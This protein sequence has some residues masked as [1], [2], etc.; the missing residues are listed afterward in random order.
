MSGGEKQRLAILRA[1]VTDPKVIIADEPASNLDEENAIILKEFFEEER[2]RDK[3]VLVVSHNDIFFDTQGG[4]SHPRYRLNKGVFQRKPKAQD[5]NR[6]V[7]R[8]C[9]ACGADVMLEQTLI[10]GGT[11][12]VD[13]CPNCKGIWLDAQD[14]DEILDFPH[15][16]T[17]ELVRAV[18]QKSGQK[19]I[20]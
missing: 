14:W 12:E 3:I 18:Q 13:I 5:P 16:F 17:K 20:P 15:N 11:V 2:N 8:S 19:V 4:S 9:A 1:L 10:Y 6:K 7:K